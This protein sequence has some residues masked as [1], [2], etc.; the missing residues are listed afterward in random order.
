MFSMTK[1]HFF[2]KIFG[3][4]KFR[5]S[6]E[7]NCQKRIRK[8]MRIAKISADNMYNIVSKNEGS[9][10]SKSYTQFYKS[11][12]RCLFYV[13]GAKVQKKILKRNISMFIQLKKIF[14]SQSNHSIIFYSTTWGRNTLTIFGQLYATLKLVFLFSA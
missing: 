10:L 3:Y 14:Q 11:M 5:M 4:L 13:Q 1:K 9:S 6:L 12:F 8:K 7:T 2:R